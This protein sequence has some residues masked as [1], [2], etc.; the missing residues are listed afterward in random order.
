[1]QVSIPPEERLSV[2]LLGFECGSDG[3]ELLCQLQGD[4]ITTFTCPFDMLQQLLA[5]IDLDDSDQDDSSSD[6][7]C[8]L[9]EKILKSI[10]GICGIQCR[11]RLITA[12][13]APLEKL[14]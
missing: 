14:P 8:P 10:P 6:T 1:M 12:I 7:D 11:D 9:D 2:T 3:Y 5:N 13:T 4:D